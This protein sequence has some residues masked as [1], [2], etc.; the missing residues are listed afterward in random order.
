M[1]KPGFK[2]HSRSRPTSG[3]FG[4]SATV[5]PDFDDPL[6][7]ITTLE[8][9]QRGGS[10]AVAAD[11][12]AG[13]NTLGADLPKLEKI[14]IKNAQKR[15]NLE[16]KKKADWEEAKRL[17]EEAEIRR[18][19]EIDNKVWNKTNQQNS[20]CRLFRQSQKY[21]P[22]TKVWKLGTTLCFCEDPRLPGTAAYDLWEFIGTVGGRE[23]WPR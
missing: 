3:F 17:A 16:E 7:E 9:I 21:Q 10:V 11:V 20:H 22:G 8:E 4:E 6:Q 19:A 12:E 18:Q 13:E 2:R 15:Y 23:T 1:V 5:D 14:R